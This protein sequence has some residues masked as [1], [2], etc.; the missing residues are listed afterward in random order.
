MA[1]P[2]FGAIQTKAKAQASTAPTGGSGSDSNGLSA[3]NLGTTFLNL[4]AQELQNQDPTQPIDPTQQVGQLISL[5]QLEQLIGIN[6]ALTPAATSPTTGTGA[7]GTGTGS[8]SKSVAGTPASPQAAFG[9]APD[10]SPLAGAALDSNQAAL[11]ALASQSTAAQ[12]AAS[13]PSVPLN[14][15][16][17]NT[18]FGGK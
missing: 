13:N 1:A 10:G 6:S 15:G 14:L 8:S 9:T 4:L 3:N 11:A 18:I 2:F 17:L 16:N 12:T 7:G 5:N